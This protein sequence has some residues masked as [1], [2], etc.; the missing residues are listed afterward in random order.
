LIIGLLIIGLLIIGLLII[1]LLVIGYWVLVIGY[2]VIKLLVIRLN[3]VI[4]C[5]VWQVSVETHIRST[6]NMKP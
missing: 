6:L 1:G 5:L 4:P 2:W 3:E